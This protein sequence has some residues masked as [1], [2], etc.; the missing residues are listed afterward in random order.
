MGSIEG[1]KMFSHIE[2][3]L[4][5]QRPIT[6][7]IFLTNYCNNK[8]PY[9]TYGRW[10][11]DAGAYFMKY[12]EF[13]TYA[14]RLRSL[15]VE[16]FILTG[17]GEPTLN[18]EIMRI[19]G[20]LEEKGIHYGINTN[21]NKLVYIKPDYLKVSLDGWDEESYE[22]HRG[23][24]AYEKVR[25]NIARYASWKRIN[26]PKT[27][28]GIQIV[29]EKAEDVF[30]FYAANADLPVDYISFRPIESTAGNYYKDSRFNAVTLNGFTEIFDIVRRVKFL[31]EKDERVTVNF[32]WNMLDVQEERCTAQWAQIAVNEHGEVMYCCHKPYQIVGHVMDEDILEK[33]KTTGTDM[34]KCDIPCRMTAPNM[35][36]A[37]MEKERKDAFF[38]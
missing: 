24:R 2:R 10:A 7:D 31:E 23:V 36:M 32:K 14:E 4:H 12:E 28:L 29:V 34:E 16:G 22:K 25:D 21:F 8:C 11:L 3:A 35:F 5:D 9:C 33:K 17:G 38:I 18:P 27:S 15:G 37:Q 30:D 13:I 20:W 19:T 6:A 1:D 26:S